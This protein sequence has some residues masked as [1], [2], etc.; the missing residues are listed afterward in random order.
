MGKSIRFVRRGIQGRSRQNFNWPGVISARSVVHITAGEVKFGTTQSQQIQPTQNFHYH[1]GA[2]DVWVTNISP[3]KNEFT[4]AV[5]GVEFHV[6]VAWDA[7]L[8]VAIT[9]TVEDEIPI[10][11]QGF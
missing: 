9:I 4:G 6:H 1:L 11:I 5:G 2:A 10:E 3:H 7:P 8:D